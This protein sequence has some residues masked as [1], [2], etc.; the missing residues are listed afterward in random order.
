MHLGIQ[1]SGAGG[2]YIFNATW[3]TGGFL[4]NNHALV[5]QRVFQ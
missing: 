2:V 3:N 4:I 1:G 5:I